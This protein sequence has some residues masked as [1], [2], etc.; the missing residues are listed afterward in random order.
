MRIALQ[1]KY[2]DWTRLRDIVQ[3][4]VLQNDQWPSI[5]CYVYE[6]G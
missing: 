4:A 2:F 5:Q 3:L 1:V 6:K